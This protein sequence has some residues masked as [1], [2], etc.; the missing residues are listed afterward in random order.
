M[1][2]DVVQ[3]A[4]NHRWRILLK[5]SVSCGTAI[6]KNV[7]LLGEIKGLFMQYIFGLSW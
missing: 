4:C 2:S 3:N 7:C 6:D 5:L 1:K